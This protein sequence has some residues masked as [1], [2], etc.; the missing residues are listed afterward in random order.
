MNEKFNKWYEEAY[1]QT[2]E[3]LPAFMDKI[4]NE[5][6]DYDSIVE[7]MAACA[8]GAA[9]AAD[10]HPNGGISGFQAS[11]VMWRF[12]QHWLRLERVSCLQL[13][14]YDDMLYPQYESKFKKHVISKKTFES[15]QNKAKDLLKEND[16][17]A[18]VVRKHWQSI[19]DGEVPFGYTVD[20]EE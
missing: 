4:L 19:A 15:L 16:D 20:K 1:N 14:N 10:S 17:A 2:I 3:T 5:E 7:A 13:I 6:Q 18:G 12:I 11:C 8:I 9:W